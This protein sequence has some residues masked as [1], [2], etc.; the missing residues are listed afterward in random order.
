MLLP[1]RLITHH[2]TTAAATTI[3][4][5]WAGE[6]LDHPNSRHGDEAKWVEDEPHHGMD[7]EEEAIQEEQGEEVLV[8]LV[9]M[10]GAV[11]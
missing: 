2:I 8:V 4:G 6:E 11:T 1:L 3:A 9:A 7:E 10:E 5:R